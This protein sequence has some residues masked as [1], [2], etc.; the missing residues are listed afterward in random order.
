VSHHTEPNDTTKSAD[1]AA[2]G[3]NHSADRP[4]TDEEA[5]AADNQYESE[6]AERRADVAR[7]E[8]EM[9]E[10]GV[11]AKGEGAVG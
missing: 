11:E 6:G 10:I 2:M 5:E 1:K 3:D 9:M 8:E 4:A 7:H